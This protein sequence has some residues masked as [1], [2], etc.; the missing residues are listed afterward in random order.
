ML[1]SNSVALQPFQ[2]LVGQN[3]S[4]KST[5]LGALQFIGDILKGGVNYALER[6]AASFYDL[7]FDIT[8]PISL[9]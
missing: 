8:E 7:C 1:R 3:A 5:F 6:L 2:I 4:G 9:Q